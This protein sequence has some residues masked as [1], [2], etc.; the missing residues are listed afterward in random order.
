MLRINQLAKELGIPNQEVLEACEKRLGLQGKSHSSNLT[1]DQADAL[2]RVFLGK[3]KGAE[4]SSPLA[5]HKPSAGVKVVKTSR[6]ASPAAPAPE[7]ETPKPAPAVLVKKAEPRPESQAPVPPPA[8]A[9]VPPPAPEPVQAEAPVAAPAPTP[10]PVAAPEPKPAATV[11]PAA[12]KAPVAP[13][14]AP[15]PPAPQESF[16]RLKVSATPAP[17][18]REEKPARYIQLPPTRPAGAP[19][20]RPG[21]NPPSAGPRPE[22]GARP[23]VQRPGQPTAPTNV[24]RSGMPPKEKAV[25]PMAT[26]TGRGEVRHE[27]PQPPSPSRR[28]YIP[29]AITELRPDQGFSR[30]KTSDTPPPTPRPQ[31]PARYI[32]LPQ[33]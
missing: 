5:L 22:A 26:N 6:E 7:P 33:P 1:D 28:P 32:Q 17:A 11:A 9:P 30:I 13:A 15:P 23:I 19:A 29:P 20:P 16:S 25:L 31:E 10:V 4:E 21:A 14:P 18:P 27:A 12:P 3:H 2:R 24:Q 8:P